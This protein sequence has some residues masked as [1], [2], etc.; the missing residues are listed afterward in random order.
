MRIIEARTAF[1]REHGED[2]LRICRERDASETRRKV[3]AEAGQL[4]LLEAA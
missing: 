3:V 1:W 4:D 2:G